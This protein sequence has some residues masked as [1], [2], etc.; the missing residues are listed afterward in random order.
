LTA[1][2]PSVSTGVVERDGIVI[3]LYRGTGNIVI[4]RS[5]IISKMDNVPGAVTRLYRSIGVSE[6]GNCIR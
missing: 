2:I 5:F 6:T 3:D 1:I 4:S